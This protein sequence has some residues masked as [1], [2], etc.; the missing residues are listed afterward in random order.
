[1]EMSENFKLEEFTFSSAA[2]RLGIQN[3]PGPNEVEN[4][5]QLCITILQ[6]VRERF[7]KPIRITSGYRCPIL[8]Q[9]VGGSKTSQHLYGEAV[10][11]VCSNNLVLWNLFKS[12]I[13]AKEIIVGQLIN[14]KNLR[15]IHVSLPNE[16]LINQILAIK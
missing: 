15:W 11:I 7:G 10:D 2:L 14:E 6:P 16:R 5:R 3:I 12:M 1:M 9:A 4:I 8:N 13:V